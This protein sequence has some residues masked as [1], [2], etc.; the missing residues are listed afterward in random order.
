MKN[1]LKTSK[2]IKKLSTGPTFR[3]LAQVVLHTDFIDVNIVLYNTGQYSTI[4][5]ST[6]KINNTLQ[7][8]I[9]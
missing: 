8:K 9:M 6:V 4:R 5:D 7:I 3:Q 1:S 2:N